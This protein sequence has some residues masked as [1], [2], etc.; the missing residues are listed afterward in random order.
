MTSPRMAGMRPALAAGR[1]QCIRST[2]LTG[3]GGP[4]TLAVMGVA[5]DPARIPVVDLLPG[6]NLLPGG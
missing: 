1:P 6:A 3:T 2:P 4:A 5:I